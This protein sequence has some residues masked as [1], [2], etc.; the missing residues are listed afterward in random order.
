MRIGGF[1]L[2]VKAVGAWSWPLTWS[3]EVVWLQIYPPG[4]LLPLRC[5]Q[6]QLRPP[7][8][9]CQKTKEVSLRGI[10]LT[11]ASKT[12][13]RYVRCWVS[14]CALCQRRRA[15]EK[16]H[17]SR[18]GGNRNRRC[19][20]ELTSTAKRF[21]AAF[22]LYCSLIFF[23]FCVGYEYVLWRESRI[24]WHEQWNRA[25]PQRLQYRVFL[26][27][28]SLFVSQRK[29]K[30]CDR[31]RKCVFCLRV[32]LWC[33]GHEIMCFSRQ[34]YLLSVTSEIRHLVCWQLWRMISVWMSRED[35]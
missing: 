31:V 13:G 16:G 25:L 12:L 11:V 10:L 29:K 20:H 1:F 22:I 34:A 7:L 8:V 28:F 19:G 32:E 3:S 2:S 17:V 24:K 9:E 23:S 35:T 21:V 5:A 6:G 4:P 27:M 33:V 30:K 26:G 15:A 18:E 14:H